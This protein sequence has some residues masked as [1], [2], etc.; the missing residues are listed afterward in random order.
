MSATDARPQSELHT[1]PLSSINVEEGFNPRESYD[2][3]ELTRLAESVRLHGVLQPIEVAPAENGEYR[4]IAGHRRY[5]AAGEAALIEVPALVR[6]DVDEEA[7]GLDHAIIENVLRADLNPV[8]EAR[9]YKRLMEEAGLTRRGVA[10]RCSVSQKR[11]TERLAILDVP[12]ALHPKIADGTIPASAVKPLGELAKVHPALPAIAYKRVS[13]EPVHQWDEPVTW[14][15]FCD[16][17]IDIVIGRY[18]EEAADLPPDVFD[19]S[20][21]HAVRRF[22]LDEKAQ[23]DLVKLCELRGIAVD[24]YALHFGAAEI[25]HAQ[26]IGAAFPP[27]RSH[28]VLIVGQEIADELAADAI[29]RTLKDERARAKRERDW[30]RQRADRTGTAAGGGAPLSEE[31]QAEQRRTQ[32]EAD[33]EAR[34]QAA[35]FNDELGIAIVK[36]LSKT[37]VDERV[38]KI[39]A[40]VDFDGELDKIA[41]RGA[42]YG[43]P[44]WVETVTLKEGKPAKRVYVERAS[45]AEDKARTYIAVAKTAADFA[46]RLLALVVMAHLA[47]E[48]AVAQSKRSFYSLSFGHYTG[49][50]LPWS[51]EVL[52]LIEAIAIERLPEHLTERLRELRAEREQRQA[53]EAAAEEARA[54]AIAELREQ[55]PAMAAAQRH[56]AVRELEAEHGWGS[57]SSALYTEIRRLEQAEAEAALADGENDAPAAAAAAADGEGG[58]AEL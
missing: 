53:E 55:L 22:A 36:T 49:P 8:E 52:S 3:K 19:T 32:R 50:T 27:D 18:A 37:K 38:V 15:D 48:N 25:E 12:E 33:A 26:K 57:E 5:L 39:L 21:H 46:G 28:G 24:S 6:Y 1:I 13:S 30:E 51:R 42:R 40:A 7:R 43:F 14:S 9:A 44:G 56:G 23:K 2:A 29:K 35:L 31:E 47:D 4:L 41:M 16:D 17:P 11:V 58:D 10:E 45:E 54:A 20:G 34:R